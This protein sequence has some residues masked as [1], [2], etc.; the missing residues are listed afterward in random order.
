M[1]DIVKENRIRERGDRS[2]K[3]TKEKNESNMENFQPWRPDQGMYLADT[4][5]AGGENLGGGR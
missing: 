1:K 3:G 2:I 5:K 4:V